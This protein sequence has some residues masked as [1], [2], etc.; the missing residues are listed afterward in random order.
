MWDIHWRMPKWNILRHRRLGFLFILLSLWSGLATQ[1][2]LS[3]RSF[4]IGGAGIS[5]WYR[6]MNGTRRAFEDGDLYRKDSSLRLL[7]IP[8]LN[9]M[10]TGCEP[11]G[12][13][14]CGMRC[15]RTIRTLAFT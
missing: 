5:G 10:R 7:P 1:Y 11:S 15:E 3:L 6:A 12:K 9:A 4:W 13:R 14:T 8:L 2:R